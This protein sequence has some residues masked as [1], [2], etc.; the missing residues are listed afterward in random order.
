MSLPWIC[1]PVS[2][3]STLPYPP[4][5]LTLTHQALSH[6]RMAYQR[7]SGY[8]K[9]PEPSR[10]T[11]TV[12]P[13]LPYLSW[14]NPNKGSGLGCPSLFSVPW[15]AQVPSPVA[16]PHG[17]QALTLPLGSVRLMHVFLSSPVPASF[18]GHTSFIRP[19]PSHTCLE[20]LGSFGA[21]ANSVT[22]S[23]YWRCYY[24]RPGLY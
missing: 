21:M 22:V 20:Q 17:M 1:K 8:P 12:Y 5:Y 18:C 23:C 19:H 6:P 15:P 2:P 14:R 7:K 11:Q 16:L 13:A 24:S 9:S 4:P 3:E 10:M